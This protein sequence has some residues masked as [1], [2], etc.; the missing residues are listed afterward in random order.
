[1]LVWDWLAG[2]AALPFSMSNIY[3]NGSVIQ[4]HKADTAVQQAVNGERA[5]RISKAQFAKTCFAQPWDKL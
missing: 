2:A 4:K 3:T 5:C 1:M